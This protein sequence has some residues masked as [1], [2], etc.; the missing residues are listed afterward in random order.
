MFLQGKALFDFEEVFNTVFL[1][2]ENV[3]ICVENSDS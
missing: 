1:E 3:C 2:N